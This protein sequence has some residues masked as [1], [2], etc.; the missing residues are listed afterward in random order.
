MESKHLLLAP[1]VFLQGVGSVISGQRKH[2][3]GC[4]YLCREEVTV[5]IG[6]LERKHS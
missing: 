6:E 1:G 4:Q 5:R 2:L 3:H